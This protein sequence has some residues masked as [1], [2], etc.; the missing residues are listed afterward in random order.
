M[1]NEKQKKIRKKLVFSLI[2]SLVLFGIGTAAAALI[3]YKFS[4]RLTDVL[5]IGGA[6]VLVIGLLLTMIGDPS[7]AV[8]RRFGSK[9]AQ[10]LTEIDADAEIYKKESG[11]YYK[12]FARGGSMFTFAFSNLTMILCGI[13]L[14]ILSIIC[15]GQ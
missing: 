4:Y 9:G 15:V 12:K 14:I 13:F 11:K 5:F 7:P 6:I 1:L 3:A 10:T 8:I 2:S